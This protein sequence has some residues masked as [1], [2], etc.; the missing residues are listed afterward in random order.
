[1]LHQIYDKNSISK[2][3]VAVKEHNVLIY[4][5]NGYARL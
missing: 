2:C 3:S 1:M 5:G 4:L